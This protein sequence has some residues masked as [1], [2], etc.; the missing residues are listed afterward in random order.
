MTGRN[1]SHFLICIMSIGLFVLHA[2]RTAVCATQ[3]K[4]EW[5]KGSLYQKPNHSYL[6]DYIY[7]EN[8]LEEKPLIEDIFDS[9]YAGSHRKSLENLL[10]EYEKK[11]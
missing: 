6:K 10:S 1:S 11:E 5:M 7:Q 9:E 4:P 2:P 3:L 8:G